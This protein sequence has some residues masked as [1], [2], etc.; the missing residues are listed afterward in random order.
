MLGGVR[1]EGAEEVHDSR[2]EVADV[3]PALVPQDQLGHH[4]QHPHLGLSPI[5]EHYVLDNLGDGQHVPT[6]PLQTV[7]ADSPDA[8]LRPVAILGHLME[9]LL[10]LGEVVPLAHYN[11]SS[12]IQSQAQPQVRIL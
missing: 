2:G 1:F 6:A 8:L 4:L 11:K 3:L 9:V 5:A 10:D 7:L 12:I